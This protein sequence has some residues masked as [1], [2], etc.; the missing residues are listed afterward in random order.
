MI[1]H[2]HK[3][4]DI[5]L[6]DTRKKAVCFTLSWR[7]VFL[8]LEMKEYQKDHRV[9]NK[10]AEVMSEL[11]KVK[12]V[13]PKTVLFSGRQLQRYQDGQLRQRLI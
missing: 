4:G 10:C 7:G 9:K 13:K 12:E 8:Y 2:R 1:N 11:F 3:P 5:L 6:Q